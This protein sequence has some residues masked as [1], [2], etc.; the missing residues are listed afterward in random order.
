MFQ[1]EQDSVEVKKALLNTLLSHGG[2]LNDEFVSEYEKAITC[3]ERMLEIDPENYRAHYNLG[4]TYF[5]LGNIEKAL[6]SYNKSLKI[7]PDYKYCYYNIGYLY[8]NVGELEK[9]MDNYEKALNIDHAF[10]YALKA[11]DSV[12]DQ[13]YK[14]K[15]SKM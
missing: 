15:R 9:A 3:F 8:E 1:K 7:N 2:Y 14:L 12:R 11:R 5:N 4:I 6:D 10:I 13:I